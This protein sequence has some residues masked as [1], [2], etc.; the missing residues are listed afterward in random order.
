EI[1]E[2]ADHHPDM[3][4]NY[5]RVTFICSTHSEG[6]VTDKDI[7]LARQIEQAFASHST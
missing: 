3:H 7:R 1:A 6:G 2:A 4:I 5:T